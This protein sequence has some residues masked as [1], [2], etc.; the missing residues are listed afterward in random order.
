MPDLVL[1]ETTASRNGTELVGESEDWGSNYYVFQVK[2]RLTLN[3]VTG[4]SGID[5][6]GAVGVEGRGIEAADGFAKPRRVSPLSCWPSLQGRSPIWWIG[7]GCC[8][9]HR[10][11]C[12]LQPRHLVCLRFWVRPLRGYCSFL[13]LLLAPVRR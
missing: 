1:A 11:G 6:I 12:S 8:S 4:I 9:S 5:A 13:H 7:A 10:A 3:G 2:T